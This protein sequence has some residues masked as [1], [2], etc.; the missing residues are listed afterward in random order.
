[1][2]HRR[3]VI[4]GTVLGGALSALTE[5]VEAVGPQSAA[6]DRLVQ[7]RQVQDRLLDEIAK[8]VRSVRDEIERQ[9]TFG[10]IAAVREPLRTFLRANGKFPDFIEVGSDVWQQ[11]YDW[12]VRFQQPIALG[13]TA[14]E[15]RYTILL[16]AT[17]IVMRPDMAPGFIGVPFDN[18]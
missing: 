12:H 4:T 6:Q 15:G 2:V 3:A 9:H 17:N 8:A 16:L 14:A 5:S 1:M 11:V 18:R 7:D 13:R 10:E